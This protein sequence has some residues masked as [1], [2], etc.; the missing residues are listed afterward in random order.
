M[1]CLWLVLLEQFRRHAFGI[2]RAP[3]SLSS[4]EAV[5]E[6]P[7]EC[8]PANNTPGQ[9][10]HAHVLLC[11]A[12][13]NNTAAQRVPPLNRLPHRLDLPRS[14]ELWDSET[15]GQM[16]MGNA[17]QRTNDHYDN[18]LKKI[19]ACMRDPPPCQ[20][21][22]RSSMHTA[23]RQLAQCWANSRLADFQHTRTNYVMPPPEG[24]VRS[25][26]WPTTRCSVDDDMFEIDDSLR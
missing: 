24:Q 25:T 22:A 1:S 26:V 14:D 3:P 17:A 9:S 21:K 7:C 8:A 4:G 16:I 20:Q 18:M 5:H 23:P 12:V 19:H 10:A 6:L 13:P 15:T 2:A 11:L